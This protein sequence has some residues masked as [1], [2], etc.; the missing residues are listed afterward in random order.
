MKKLRVAVLAAVLVTASAARATPST[1]VWSPATTAVQGF[2]V[3]HL[4]YDT[5]FAERGS[6][7]IDTGLTMGV[8]PFEKVVGEVGVDFFYPGDT[9]SG[10]YLNAKLAVPE[11]ALGAGLP[12]VSA[13]VFNVGFEED[14]TDYNI[15]HAE[16]S[17]TFAA[18]G[19]LAIGG[20]YGLNDA[21]LVDETGDA[22]QAGLIAS[23]TGPELNLGLPGI[24]KLVP[25][26]DVMTGDSSFGAV[27]AG[28][29][30]Y[31]APTVA[32]VTGPVF[33]LNR[34][35]QPGRAS[36]MWTFQLDVDFPGSGG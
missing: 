15:F 12:G 20:Y 9:E 18:I 28:A 34:D 27:G 13:G 29:A 35:V 2:L 5:F 7:Q 8:L 4:T 30:L 25:A 23:W 11:G 36:M 3:P 32:L 22:A 31:F 26:V 16:V 19:T 14:V 24:T 17:K 21:L 1:V 6:Y 10:F 33:F